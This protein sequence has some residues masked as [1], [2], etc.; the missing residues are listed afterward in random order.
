M[1]LPACDHCR[2]PLI[3]KPHIE[4]ENMTVFDARR[5]MGSVAGVDFCGS[6]CF[7]DWMKADADRPMIESLQPAN[8]DGAIIGLNGKIING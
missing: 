7:T 2:A 3:G 6:E 5:G 4:I 1:K 8:Q